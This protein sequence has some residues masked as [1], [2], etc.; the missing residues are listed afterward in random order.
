MNCSKKVILTGASGLIGKETIKPL[1]ESGFEVY[2]L[3]IDKVKPD[4]GVHWINCNLF[5]E[6]SVK[7]AFEEVKPEYLLNFA[8]C[9]TEDYLTSN[10]NFEFVKAGLNM[11]KCFKE[12]GGKRAV[13]TGTCFEYKFKDEPIREDDELNPATVYAKCKNALRLLSE[14]YC[15]QNEIEFGWG[16]IFYV[17]GHGEHEKRLTSFIINNLKNDKEVVINNGGLI[18]DYMYTKDIAGAF[19]EFLDTN[20]V[21]CVNICT[22]KGISLKD[23]AMT[24]AKRLGKENLLTIKQE[25]TTQPPVIVGDNRRLLDEVGYDLKYSTTDAINEILLR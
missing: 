4:N 14:A 7:A 22:G 12:N 25:P 10:I 21:G 20:V 1:Q 18:K 13:F 9:T 19:V 5:D 17:Y 23:Y 6:H 16:R 8:W 2:A 3:T 15:E 11:L 24:I